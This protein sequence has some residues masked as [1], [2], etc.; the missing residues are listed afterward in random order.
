MSVYFHNHDGANLYVESRYKGFGMSFFYMVKA[1][2]DLIEGLTTPVPAQGLV[3]FYNYKSGT[4]AGDVASNEDLSDPRFVRQLKTFA[5]NLIVTNIQSLCAI[6]R[7]ALKLDIETSDIDSRVLNDDILRRM[8][9]FKGNLPSWDQSNGSNQYDLSQKLFVQA[10]HQPT[11]VNAVDLQQSKDAIL[12]WLDTVWNTR[13]D[14]R[15]Y[16]KDMLA[17]LKAHFYLAS[18]YYRVAPT[19]LISMRKMPDFQEAVRIYDT[20]LA[21]LPFSPYFVTSCAD[22]DTPSSTNAI[23]Y[24][25]AM[26]EVYRDLLSPENKQ[27]TPITDLSV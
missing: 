5:N 24:M 3:K 9:A 8:R 17:F 16:K 2:L 7:D 27:A 13:F 15:D 19:I 22:R 11:N 12:V 10:H 14:S 18:C 23:I 26:A 21:A 4:L 6:F 1:Y 20:T 25:D